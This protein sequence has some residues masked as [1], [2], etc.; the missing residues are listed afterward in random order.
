MP[1]AWLDLGRVRAALGDAG[2]AMLAF[3][4]AHALQ[5]G[6]VRPLRLSAALA[7]ERADLPDA[8]ER[9]TRAI[10]IAPRDA[11]LRFA[12]AAHASSLGLHAAAVA[13]LDAATTLAPDDAAG[14]SALLVELHYDESLASIEALCAGHGAWNARHGRA[15]VVRPPR[16]RNAQRLRIG[17]LSPRF[18]DAPLEALLVP[19]LEAHDRSRFE[20]VAYAA[21]PVSGAAAIRRTVDH[22]RDLPA[23]DDDAA[24]T[25][26]A[27]ACDLLVDLAGH[28]PGN[29]LPLLARGPAAC[30]ATW[31]DYFDTTGVPAIDFLIGD[32]WHTPIAH[33]NRFSERLVLMPEG[34]FAY[35]PPLA[36]PTANDR[37]A[38][39]PIAFGSFNRLAKIGDDVVRT[40]AA[41][42]HAVPAATLTLRASAF[43]SAQTIAYVREKWRALDLPVERVGFLPFVSAA[44][45][46]ASYATIDIALDP[47]PFNGGVTTCDALAHGVPVV[48]LAGERMVSRQ[49]VALLNAARCSEWIADSRQAYVAIAVSLAGEAARE[50]RRRDLQ[51]RMRSSPLFDVVGFARALEQAFVAMIGAKA[52]RDPIVLADGRR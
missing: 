32:A 8:I 46:H 21:H 3:D 16:R 37:R 14:H 19:V 22:W 15:D 41:I 44:E 13:D 34:R 7:G 25:I 45:L 43:R 51:A 29:R 10:A 48:A 42:L 38:P 5:P 40:W 6:D 50:G 47:F 26:A 20:V 18:G 12:R 4:R 1:A 23:D 31:L 11:G 39:R 33:A 24:E 28:A 49:G 30:Q 36:I 17:Y 2:G 35:R 52:G 27:D 9:L